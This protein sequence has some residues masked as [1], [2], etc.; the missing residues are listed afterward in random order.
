MGSLRVGF[1]GV[2]RTT[3]IF[4]LWLGEKLSWHGWPLLLLLLSACGIALHRN[5]AVMVILTV[6]TAID[7]AATKT[8]QNAVHEADKRRDKM[9]TKQIQTLTETVVEVKRQ[10]DTLTAMMAA[11]ERRDRLSAKRDTMILMAL[12]SRSELLDFVTKGGTEND[13]QRK[14]PSRARSVGKAHGRANRKRS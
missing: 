10:G 4:N 7:A 6:Q 14:N 3:R 2:D 8:L 12:E 13:P 11:A 1:E 9:M 5:D